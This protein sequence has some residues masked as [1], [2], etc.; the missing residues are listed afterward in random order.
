[1]H[2]GAGQMRELIAGLWLVRLVEDADETPDHRGVIAGK[3]YVA[4]GGF[5]PGVKY[6]VLDGLGRVR[7]QRLEFAP[8]ITAGDPLFDE[9]SARIAATPPCPRRG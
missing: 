1:M 5:A 9:V 2:E 6:E 4:F 8:P 3:F 7:R